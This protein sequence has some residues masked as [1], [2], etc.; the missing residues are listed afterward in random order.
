MIGALDREALLSDGAMNHRAPRPGTPLASVTWSAL[1][2]HRA[3]SL[4][5]A[6]VLAAGALLAVFGLPPVNLHPPI[7]RL[8]IMDP[9]CG[10]TRGLQALTRGD[11]ARAWRYNPLVIVLGAGVVGTG[12]RALL[13][14]WSGKWLTMRVRSKGPVWLLVVAAMIA[15]EV[16]QQLHAALLTARG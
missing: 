12:V 14:R 13:G 1:D 4:L 11:I 2:E 7:H 9:L 8:G 16:N 15:L 5:A 3:L 10:G 6:I